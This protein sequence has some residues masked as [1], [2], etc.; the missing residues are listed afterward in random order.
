MFWKRAN[1]NEKREQ[2]AALAELGAF[3]HAI[4]SRVPYCSPPRKMKNLSA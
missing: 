3:E 1:D 2:E 4:Q